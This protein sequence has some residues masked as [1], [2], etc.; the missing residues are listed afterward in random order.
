MP[1]L[2]TEVPSGYCFSLKPKDQQGLQPITRPEKVASGRFRAAGVTGM[3]NPR[4][5]A[6]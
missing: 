4:R 1:D 3:R 2:C 6:A 5:L